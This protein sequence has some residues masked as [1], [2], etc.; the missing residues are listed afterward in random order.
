MKTAIVFYSMSGN[1]RWTAERIAERTD[2]DLIELRCVKEFPDKGFRKFFW[3]GKSAVM[4]EKPALQPYEFEADKYDSIILGSPVWAAN[5]APPLRTFI[6]ENAGFL[7]NKVISAFVCMSGSG[8]EKALEKLSD[9]ISLSKTMIL[10][11]PKER[12]NPENEVKIREFC[13]IK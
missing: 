1:V 12:E 9:L 6:S 7:E 3:G 8:G 4:K 13:D 5:I 10:I 11:D 2:G